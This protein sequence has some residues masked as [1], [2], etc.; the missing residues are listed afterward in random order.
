VFLPFS[1]RAKKWE[2]EGLAL[3]H[4]AHAR[5]TEILDPFQLAPLVGLRVVE[6]EF[7]LRG[8]K[9]T[10]ARYLL[11]HAGNQWSGGVLPKPLADGSFVCILNPGHSQRRNRITL[12]EEIAHKYL[13]HVPTDL[14]LAGDGMR[15][16]GYDKSQEIEAYGVG[17][18]ALLPWSTFFPRVNDGA[19]IEDL[20]DAY[21]VTPDLTKY[22]I[23]ITGAYRLYLSRQKASQAG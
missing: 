20:A 18:A 19:P 2:P 16:R 23:K 7:A 1:D 13:N 9:A 6:A 14:T 21:D 3:R 12:M 8:L 17:A 15:I 5:L 22:R 4:L 11:E 10:D